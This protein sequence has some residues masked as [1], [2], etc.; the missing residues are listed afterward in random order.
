MQALL[1]NIGP[2]T[3]KKHDG[4]TGGIVVL[5]ER[6]LTYCA[7]HNSAT[8]TIDTNK[9][10]YPN[11]LLAYVVIVWQL[12]RK[13]GGA[14][15]LFLHGTINDYVWLAPVVLFI[16]H[17]QGKKVVL[18]KFAG[19]FADYYQNSGHLRR[20]CIRQ[21]LHRA[22]LLFWE[23]KALV[24]FGQGFNSRS[25]WFPNVRQRPCTLRPANQPYRKRFVYLSRVEREKGLPQ[26]IEAFEQLGGEYTLDVYGP[27]AGLVTADI[28]RSNIRYRGIVP[29]DKVSYTLARYDVLVLPTLWRT[30]GYPGI[31]IEAFGVGLPVIA[32]AIGGIPE[33]VD[34]GI[35]G[36][37]I[38]PG[39]SESIQVAVRHFTS[40]NYP[41][42]SR[43]ALASFDTF[44]EER[45][46]ARIY[47]TITTL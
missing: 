5:F 36:L 17:L 44:D 1:L 31:I 7:Q 12:L 19:N 6:W 26:L 25:Y 14:Q 34:N 3:F 8:A 33:I 32:S 22:D 30:E 35:S 43:R 16:S 28:N 37:L 41:Q 38:A 40:D 42:F 21:V 2:R 47:T 45:T 39:Q 9:H 24:T 46:Y 4:R 11:R 15:V 20:F 10:N 13:S 29:P 18:R 27:L 23:T